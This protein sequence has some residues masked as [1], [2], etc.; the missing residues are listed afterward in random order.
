MLGRIVSLPL[1]LLGALRTVPSIARDTN[2]M[3]AHTE[4]LEE[5]AET[6]RALPELRREMARVAEATEAIGT[7]DA[8][9]A[10]IEEAMPVLVEVQRHLARMPETI[11]R[12]DARISELSVLLE[13]L[14]ESLTPLGRI[15][16]R[17]PGQRSADH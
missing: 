8:R 6:T 4:V 14:Q 9:M 13:G 12:L 15:A 10:T 2:R 1:D 3:A 11:E 7:I 17:L 5:V 16:R